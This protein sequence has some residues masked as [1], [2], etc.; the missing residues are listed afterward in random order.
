MKVIYVVL[1]TLS[2]GLQIDPDAFQVY[3]VNVANRYVEL[4][5]WYYMPQSLHCILLHGHEV[6]RQFSLPIGLLTTSSRIMQQGF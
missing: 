2:S 3:C 5:S 6:V 1:Q 4:Y